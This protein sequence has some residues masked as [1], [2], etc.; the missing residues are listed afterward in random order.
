M[1]PWRFALAAA[2]AASLA[3]SAVASASPG[4]ASVTVAGDPYV[5][6][7]SPDGGGTSVTQLRALDRRAMATRS[8]GRR[9]ELPAGVGKAPREGLSR[10]GRTLVLAARPR[11]GTTRFAL[12]DTRGLRLRRVVALRGVF[13]YD[14]MSPDGS[15]L[16]VIRYLSSDRRH[17][18]VQAM[19]TSDARPALRT[20]V[21]KGEPGEQMSGLP[22]SRATS[23]NG[24]WVYTLYDGAGKTPF[25]HALSTAD[26]FTMCIDLDAL[27]GRSDLA[28]LSLKLSPNEPT[29]NVTGT[30]GKPVALINPE[31]FQVTEPPATATTA[32]R[33]EPTAEENR[34]QAPWIIVLA[35][36]AAVLLAAGATI[37]R[38]TRHSRR[39][40]A[41][42]T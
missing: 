18:A 29:L 25:V 35:L 8:I 40:R 19:D 14:A 12:I 28:S 5:Y 26:R 17:Y 1:T 41:E 20:V 42:Q 30:N 34:A 37:T 13:S 16:Y 2:A 38:Q 33:K 3:G 31:S 23:P 27:A 7:V 10:D 24:N 9:F 36:A 21:E 32:P 39:G 4:A 11:S 15:T 6:M 22:I